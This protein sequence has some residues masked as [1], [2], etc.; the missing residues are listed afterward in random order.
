M[1]A[2][3]IEREV[4]REVTPVTRQNPHF[5]RRLEAG[6]KQ[7][8]S[9]PS[10]VRGLEELELLFSES[11]ARF[12]S[13]VAFAITIAVAWPLLLAVLMVVWPGILII[14][15]AGDTNLRR[16]AGEYA[17]GA[18]G[19]VTL[20]MIYFG[21]PVLVLHSKPG[22]VEH[23][24]HMLS[25]GEVGTIEL[26]FYIASFLLLLVLVVYAWVVYESVSL[27]VAVSLQSRS[28]FLKKHWKQEL[29]MTDVEKAKVFGKEPGE[30]VLVGDL[31]GVLSQYPGWKG[32]FDAAQEDI[33]A[34]ISVRSGERTLR[35][36]PP[37]TDEDEPPPASP[38]QKFRPTL[39]RE[40]TLQGHRL[41]HID[42]VVMS[43]LDLLAPGESMVV[44]ASKVTH[45]LRTLFF[46]MP[47]HIT[48]MILVCAAFRA[49][50]PR[51]WVWLYLGGKFLPGSPVENTIV[52][53]FL[54]TTFVTTSLWLLLFNVVRRQYRHNIDQMSLVTA[55]VSLEQRHQYM[56]TVLC[57]DPDDKEHILLA[58]G[59]P[60]V[61]LA[62]ADNMRIWWTIREYAIVDSLDERVD[63]EV[64]LG[65]ALLYL[66]MMTVYLVADVFISGQIT[67]FT[68]VCVNDLVTVGALLVV[69]L[70]GCVEVNE[71]LRSHSSTILRARHTL[72][73]PEEKVIGTAETEVSEFLE[74]AGRP[75][76]QG[77]EEALR[78]HAH[79]V[80]KIFTADT[81]QTIFGY[82]VTSTNV[83]QL[84]V[85]ILCGIGSAGFSLNKAHQYG[86]LTAHEAAAQTAARFVQVVAHV[87]RV[88]AAPGG[89][90]GVY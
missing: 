85:A 29:V 65:V 11:K 72:W 76:A 42:A 84:L 35:S 57:V 88:P 39:Q 75:A 67:A 28:R 62:Q 5:V 25:T 56:K 40:R 10:V 19:I 20:V 46:S 30:A 83:A 17:L 49:S 26:C 63:L 38:M 3:K 33:D 23:F 14:L 21:V 55:V 9:A 64:V 43:S 32:S 6:R 54:I 89:F 82:E 44:F 34:L 73:C 16:R 15:Y 77:A 2:R 60:F 18:I 1:E 87:Q 27:E 7:H 81:L 79:L 37:E 61:D 80:E 50:I 47:T 90:L 66:L 58:Q 22:G 59:L 52:L 68:F 69:S 8:R 45:F 36:S 86:Q 24:L 70:L 48:V 12:I 4:T 31:L 13:T 53:T 51:L 74:S 71:M 78:L 41:K